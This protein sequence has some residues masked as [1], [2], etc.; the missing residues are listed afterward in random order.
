[1]QG[2]WGLAVRNT[3]ENGG[4]R[5]LKTKHGL[6]VLGVGPVGGRVRRRGDGGHWA[7]DGRRRVSGWGRGGAGPRGVRRGACV[8][9]MRQALLGG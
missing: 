6:R 7:S 5:E 4:R 2:Y 3:P 8:G 9:P 1:M